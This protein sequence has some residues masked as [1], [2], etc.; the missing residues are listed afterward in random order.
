MSYPLVKLPKFEFLDFALI[1][2]PLMLAAQFMNAPALL[3]FFLAIICIIALASK[4]GEV[5]ED[6]A[7]HFGSNAGGFLNATFGNAAEFIIA[8]IAIRA[9]LLELVKA[10]LTGSIIGNMLFVIGASFLT[11]GL[12]FR[13]QRFNIRAAGLNST[14]LLIGVSSMMIPSALF[15]F[16]GNAPGHNIPFEA[17]ELSLFVS[18][19]L[20]ALYLLSLLFSFHTHA[21]LFRKNTTGQARFSRNTALIL[22]L[23]ITVCLAVTSEIFT[24][25]VEEVTK[26]LGFSQLFMGAIVIALVGNAAEHLSAV[27]AA[28]KD[29]IDLALSITV[30][31][32]IQIAIFIAP[33]LVLVSY[34]MGTPMDLVFTLFELL[35][36]FCAVLIVNEISSDGICNWFEGAQLLVMYLILAGLFFFI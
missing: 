21:Y 8:I 22:L 17:E 10:S 27:K 34:L 23:L 25:H 30:G 28:Q 13:E 36:V 33:L 26:M 20:V 16:A 14:M 6:L 31:S 2:F 18:V 4:L 5:T 24:K 12:K 15:F 35:A 3:T 11:G 7:H 29:D 32:S 19:L 1:A 9:G